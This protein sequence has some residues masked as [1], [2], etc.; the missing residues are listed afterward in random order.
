MDVTATPSR[1]LNLNWSH[2]THQ[3][4]AIFILYPGAILLLFAGVAYTRD[5]IFRF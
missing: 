3:I 5:L 1:I 4:K 2:W